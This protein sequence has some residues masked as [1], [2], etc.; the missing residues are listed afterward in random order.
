MTD[1]MI[2]QS[3]TPSAKDKVPTIMLKLDPF[4]R[5]TTHLCDFLLQI[6]NSLET[7][8]PERVRGLLTDAFKDDRYLQFI[9]LKPKSSINE[10]FEQL[11]QDEYGPLYAR[12][13][14]LLGKK[15]R[16]WSIQTTKNFYKIAGLENVDWFKFFIFRKLNFELPKSRREAFTHKTTGRDPNPSIEHM[17]EMYGEMLD[18]AKENEPC[19]ICNKM[20]HWS[21]ACPAINSRDRPRQK[22][23]DRS[24]AWS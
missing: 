16:P 23:I 22:K 11:L 2:K 17:L 18:Q 19:W 9:S 4:E 8:D 1:K 15:K 14:I 12:A 21:N 24:H 13:S 7:H 10:M 6:K 20:G 5:S 3:T